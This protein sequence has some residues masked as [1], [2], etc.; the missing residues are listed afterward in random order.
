MVEEK[1][2]GFVIEGPDRH[3]FVWIVSGKGRGDWC[4]NLGPTNQVA[5]ALWQWLGTIDTIQCRTTFRRRE[6]KPRG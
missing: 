2:E 3:G 1:P 6:R 4:H 5:E